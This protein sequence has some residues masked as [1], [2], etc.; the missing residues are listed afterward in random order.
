MIP[1]SHRGSSAS[2]P[3]KT[4]LYVED[5]DD[6]WVVAELL[7]KKKF[8]LIR[9]ANAR[10]ACRAVEQTRDL[11]AILMDIQL[12]GSELDGIALT[13]LLRGS[14][15]AG[16]APADIAHCRS[17][18]PIIFVTAYGNRYSEAA[19]KQAG[20]NLLMTK[21]VDFVKLSLALANLS[22]LGVQELLKS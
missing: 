8:R 13:R 17:A 11:Y 18:V 3:L 6:N 5:E 1:L 9:A 10:E 19:L 4:V 15:S 2:S 20:G 22:L 14:L 16:T 21:P 12:S 7:L